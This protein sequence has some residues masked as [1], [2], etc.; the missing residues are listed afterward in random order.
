MVL[1]YL[2]SVLAAIAFSVFGGTLV[3]WKPGKGVDVRAVLADMRR[4]LTH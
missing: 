4:C 2:Y 1:L 3:F